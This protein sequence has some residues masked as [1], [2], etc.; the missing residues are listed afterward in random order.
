MSAEFTTSG[1]TF[2]R[3]RVTPLFA[4]PLRNYAYNARHP[5]YDVGPDD[6]RFMLARPVGSGADELGFV[7]VQN[8][9]EELKRL[10]PK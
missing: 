6:E 9:F 10:V 8:F 7:L 2:Q 3:G 5:F 1:S 4:A